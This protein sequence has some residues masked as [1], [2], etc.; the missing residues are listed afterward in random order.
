MPA[1]LYLPRAAVLLQLLLLNLQQSYIWV[2]T[3]CRVLHLPLQTPAAVDE[4]VW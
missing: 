4:R 1:V 2:D 3:C